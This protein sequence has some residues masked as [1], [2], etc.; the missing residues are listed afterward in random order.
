MRQAIALLEP[1][2]TPRSELSTT[3]LSRSMQPQ[4]PATR[5]DN[6]VYLLAFTHHYNGP[7]G[8]YPAASEVRGMG[9]FFIKYKIPGTLFFDGILAE[10]IQKEDPALIQQIR[11]W[12]LPLGYHGEETHGP[13]PVGSEL[14]GE[15]YTLNE[16]QGYRGPW[17]LTTGTNWDTAVAL[18]IDRYS[19]ARPYRIDPSTRRIDRRQPA[20][21]DH[22]RMGG[23]KLV[24]QVFGKDVTMMTSHGLESAPEGYAFRKMSNFSFDQPAIPVA[25][26]A[27]K[28]FRIGDVAEQ[29]M[30]I[31]GTNESLFWYM[32]RLHSKGDE[33]G[34]ASYRPGLLRHKLQTLD[35]SRPR[36]LLVGFSNVNESDGAST[37][38]FLQNDFFPSNPGSCW[39]TGKTLADQFEPEKEYTPS[40]TD[41]S[42]LSQLLI[43]NWQDRPPDLLPT[44]AR[45]FSLADT[46]ECL[47]RALAHRHTS[48]TLPGSVKLHLLYGPVAESGAPLLKQPTH[49]PSSL[50]QETATTL[51]NTWNKTA[52]N[53]RFIPG[54]ITLAQ[55][56]VNASEFLYAMALTILA[57]NGATVEVPPAQLFPPYADLLHAVFKPKSA[58]PLCYTQ[59][60]LWTVKPVRLKANLPPAASPSSTTLPKAIRLVFASNL[61]STGGC[62]RNDPSGADL[63]YAEYNLETR[64][65]SKLRQL[66]TQ[67]GPDW[68]P[69]LTPDG[70]SVVYDRSPPSTTGRPPQHALWQLDLSRNQEQPLLDNARFPAF[71]ASGNSLYY[72][73]RL[74][75]SHQLLRANLSRQTDQSLLAGPPLLIAT[76]GDHEELIEDPAPMP[77]NSAVAFH[78]KLNAKGASIALIPTNGGTTEALSDSDGSGHAAISPD[79]Q[80]IACTRSRDGKLLLIRRSPT[81]WHPPREI[82][83]SQNPRDY[84]TDDP[85]FSSVTEVRHSYVEWVT[86]TLLI[87][88]THGANSAKDFQF[89]RLYL[90]ANPDDATPPK[91]IDLSSAIESLVGRK[92]KDFCTASAAPLRQ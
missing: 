52:E 27:L 21:T 44:P 19:Y 2:T 42:Q 80:A 40:T 74:R 53:D 56:N 61:N 13:Y 51:V 83:L 66:T 34:E 37:A 82:P 87:V 12:N 14:L 35:R 28:I 11:D 7:G 68:F 67:A 25:L 22:T 24:Q 23:L 10:R 65:A 6:P 64:T 86:P 5:S 79:G 57:T 54:R 60:Q 50:I 43:Q 77:D 89:A 73:Q 45:T 9:E 16:A 1:K 91:R 20:A 8:Y 88:S 32:G 81:G 63:F 72:S 33:T 47:A 30:S 36:L 76:Q 4:S 55:Y 41:I 58:Q 38:Q 62:H 18:V 3:P 85:R 92:S 90:F 75:Q 70:R 84:L 78:R 49:F 69:A 48:L 39:V 15:V 29:V 17:S 71:D 46:F 31:A 59:G 26:H